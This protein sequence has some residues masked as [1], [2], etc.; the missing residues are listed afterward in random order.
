MNQPTTTQPAPD[1][2]SFRKAIQEFQPNS[3]RVPFN[4][5]KPFHYSIATLRDKQ[6]SYSVIAELLQQNG[7]QTSRARVAEY[8]R[9]VLEGGKSR[10]RR[11]RARNTP[12]VKITATLQSLSEKA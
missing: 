7:V 4:N 11:K 10:R 2:E 12:A 6:A 9:V 8:G 1:L 3:H 5:L